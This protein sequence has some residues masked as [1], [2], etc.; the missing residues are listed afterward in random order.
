MIP[1][2]FVF[3]DALPLTPTGKVQ[4]NALPAPKKNRPDVD[5]VFVAPRTVVEQ[6]LAEIWADVLKLERV[7]INANFL[8][9]GGHSLLALQLIARVRMIFQVQI[10]L[11]WVFE[12]ENL[13]ELAQAIAQQSTMD[14][15]SLER[16]LTALEQLPEGEV[17][18]LLDQN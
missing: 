2:A 18:Q 4:R 14:G 1:A 17:T 5:E 7:G 8:A 10:P 15:V 6:L 3:L 13:G 12:K 9:L 11:R 16:L